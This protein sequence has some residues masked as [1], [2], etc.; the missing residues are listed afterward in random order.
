LLVVSQV[1]K[2]IEIVEKKIEELEDAWRTVEE[3]NDKDPEESESIQNSLRWYQ[4]ALIRLKPFQG[5]SSRVNLKPTNWTT[6]LQTCMEGHITYY[7]DLMLGGHAATLV[8]Y[9]SWMCGTL[10]TVGLANCD[11]AAPI[12]EAPYDAVQ[13]HNM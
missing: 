9:W 4:T 7:I 3:E 8:G 13:L 11:I 1:S 12:A 10:H 5:T 2:A 6:L